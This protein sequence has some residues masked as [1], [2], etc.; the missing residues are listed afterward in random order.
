MK[1][2]IISTV[3]AIVILIAIAIF[4]IN[5]I[6][7]IIV[8]LLGFVTFSIFYKIISDLYRSE[9]LGEDVDLECGYEEVNE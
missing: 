8:A 4:V 1:K 5:Y 3:I 6:Q 2:N 7:Y 9:V